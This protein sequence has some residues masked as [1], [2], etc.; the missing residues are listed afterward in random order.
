MKRLIISVLFR[1]RFPFKHFNKFHA[2]VEHNNF[3]LQNISVQLNWPEVRQVNMQIKYMT[4]PLVALLAADIPISAEALLA[5]KWAMNISF[6]PQLA[7]P[8]GVPLYAIPDV[9]IVL[10]FLHLL[11]ERAKLF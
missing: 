8:I 1:L 2:A 9:T 7:C 10:P 3:L 4:P 6:F 5:G 11:L